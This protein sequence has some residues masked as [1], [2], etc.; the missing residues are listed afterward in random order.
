MTELHERGAR[1]WAGIVVSRETFAAALAS[2]LGKDATSG[3]AIAALHHDVYLA[4]AAAAGDEAAARACDEIAVREVE[5]AARR[6]R[7]TDTQARD[8]QSDVR[9]L[10]FSEDEGRSAAIV[11]FTGRGDLRGY[12]RVVAARALSR[13]MTRDRREVELADD[14]PD[15]FGSALDPE[16]VMLREHYRADVDAAFRAALAALSARSRAVLRYHLLEGWSIDQIG[17]RYGVSRSSA[18]RWV[19]AAHEEL[20]AGIRATLAT[21]LQIPESQVDSIVALVTSRVEASIERL[22]GSTE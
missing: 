4:I 3:P 19:K 15:A 22:L 18:A 9:R 14:L 21:R 1:S 13:R 5:F 16:V 11:T 12:L 6:L 2:R 10:M 20:G 7:A 17:E 8:V